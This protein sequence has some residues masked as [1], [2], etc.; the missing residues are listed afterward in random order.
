MSF[1]LGQAPTASPCSPARS[2]QHRA[3]RRLSLTLEWSV[4]GVAPTVRA[5]SDV[6]I[7]SGASSSS[8]WTASWPQE[9]RR[10][11]R[12]SRTA[13]DLLGALE[14]GRVS[15]PDEEGHPRSAVRMDPGRP[16]LDGERPTAVPSL[17]ADAIRRRPSGERPPLPKNLRGAARFWLAMIAL[18]ALAPF[19]GL[20]ASG[21]L[22]GY[23]DQTNQAVRSLF[24]NVQSPGLTALMG[25]VAVL[26][27][28]WT[29]GV[30]RWG[31]IATLVF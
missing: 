10:L 23:V 27:S 20:S 18:L 11:C 28:V 6:D 9:E 25:A 3:Q 21:G 29:V 2:I 8:R 4:R 24:E 30:L 26:G 19:L 22:G 12:R 14:G 15:T 5:D 7:P 16:A 13:H 1:G 31:T 17:A